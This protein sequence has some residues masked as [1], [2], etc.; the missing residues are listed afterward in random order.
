MQPF[1][2]S[3]VFVMAHF[4][5]YVLAALQKYCDRPL[6]KQFTGTSDAPTWSTISYQT[7]L[8]DVE[9]TAAYWLDTLRKPS[10]ML[11]PTCVVGLWYCPIVVL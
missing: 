8:V 11:P 10:L 1:P 4:M 5:H 2:P 6:F 3:P 7:F 9:K